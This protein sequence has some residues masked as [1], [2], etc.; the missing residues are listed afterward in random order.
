MTITDRDIRYLHFVL[1]YKTNQPQ[2]E[3]ARKCG[4]S[5]SYL[6]DVARGV[7]PIPPERIQQKIAEA[8]GIYEGTLFRPLCEVVE[9]KE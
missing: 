1:S 5:Q 7:R 3:V 2:R 9:I 4:V 6:S 8:L